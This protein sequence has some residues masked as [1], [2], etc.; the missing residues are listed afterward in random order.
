MSDLFD[1]LVSRLGETDAETF[2]QLVSSAGAEGGA[3]V[4]RPLAREVGYQAGIEGAQALN[5]D[6]LTRLGSVE[7]STL[8]HLLRI[9]GLTD[10]VEAAFGRH[11]RNALK[12]N[13]KGIANVRFG[14]ADWPVTFDMDSTG[15]GNYNTGIP[16]NRATSI[17]ALVAKMAP[18][19][20]NC[21][22]G[23]VH[24]HNINGL[25]L[26]YWDE[27]T[28]LHPKWDWTKLE[29]Y[30]GYLDIDEKVSLGGPG[31]GGYAFDLRESGVQPWQGANIGFNYIRTDPTDT[32]EV[33]YIVQPSSTGWLEIFADGVQLGSD[34]LAQ[35][36]PANIVT[37]TLPVGSLK[38]HNYRIQNANNNAQNV[39]V[40][41]VN[42]YDS[43]RGK[44]VKII[45]AARAGWR[46]FDT[47]ATQHQ[48]VSPSHFGEPGFPDYTS[49]DD[50]WLPYSGYGYSRHIA[51]FGAS[52]HVMQLLLNSA[53]S[54]GA[55]GIDPGY[56]AESLAQ[57]R[58]GTIRNINRVVA[59]GGCV[60]LL[61]P[62]PPDVSIISAEL[63]AERAQ[64]YY[65]LAAT[66]DHVGIFD[67]RLL[68]A[69]YTYLNS[70]DF[71]KD[72]IHPNE[73]ANYEVSIVL[74]TILFG[75]I[76]PFYRPA[77]S[78][79]NSDITSLSGLT[80]PL[81]VP[82]GG[83]GAPGLILPKIAALTP[84]ASKI[85]RLNAS[86]DAELIDWI[87]DGSWTP[88]IDC[89]SNTDL[90]VSYS[91]QVGTWNK[92]GRDIEISGVIGFTP[93]YNTSSGNLRIGGL[94]FAADVNT[95]VSQINFSTLPGVTWPSS[96]T[97][98]FVTPQSGLS[99]A[100]IT[101]HKSAG[102]T[103]TAQLSMFP[104]GG[105]VVIRFRGRYAA[106]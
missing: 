76:G 43:T 13:H 6:A 1:N 35:A 19:D 17:P 28:N 75:S 11:N 99:Y 48:Y 39:Y 27:G 81:S 9:D 54:V 78:G 25:L 18:A 79:A 68:G 87:L 65:E 20:L 105:A 33:T 57:F 40:C 106:S 34:I 4:A 56:P 96:I 70:V 82:Q 72:P 59:A 80:T 88:T 83:I 92:R 15:T 50:N 7:A 101:G 85:I 8:A 24:G 84:S 104:S 32:L 98:I 38:A 63:F 23:A 2:R 14:V 12:R 36:T 52:T 94:P 90:T 49:L 74:A 26:G 100:H 22:D 3:A 97:Q 41:A 58:A 44:R 16:G 95:A 21:D 102:A 29:A 60:L 55:D 46:T 91:A 71:M 86:N 47:S 64:V 30:N 69:T 77:R 45:I 5:A 10:A 51:H 66:M 42:A 89:S 37:V 61:I 103:Q 31:Y 67:M 53:R 73:W 62:R 93:N